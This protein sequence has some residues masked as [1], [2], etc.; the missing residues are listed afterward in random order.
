MSSENPTPPIPLY[1]RL[2]RV[3]NLVT[4]VG[5][6]ILLILQA[7][8]VSRKDFETV[9]EK[10]DARVQR[11]EIALAQIVEQNKV[12]DRQDIELADHERRLRDLERLN[13]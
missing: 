1:E 3:G 9:T 5:V 7:Q 6:G 10:M 2:G 12:N 13:Q 4:P 11:I 8:F